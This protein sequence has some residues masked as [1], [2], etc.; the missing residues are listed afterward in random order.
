[1]K[2]L[3]GIALLLLSS[4]SAL[5]GSYTFTISS[6]HTSIATIVD[7]LTPD[8]GAFCNN[9]ILYN[10]STSQKLFFRW[11]GTDPAVNQDG[12]YVVP[13]PGNAYILVPDPYNPPV[14][15]VVTTLAASYSLECH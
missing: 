10:F 14:V 3:L 4:A 12:S 11:D 1:M 5:A 7:T 9:Y 8:M 2:R 13:P 6:H 15:K